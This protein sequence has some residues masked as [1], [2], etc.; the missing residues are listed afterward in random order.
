MYKLGRWVRD[1]LHAAKEQ[2][3]S[4]LVQKPPDHYLRHIIHGKCPLI[5][6]PGV[7]EKWHF[8][9]AIADPLSRQGHPVYVLEHLGYNTRTIHESAELVRK[10]I[11]EQH[12]YDAVIVA[13]SKGGLIGK[14]VLAH[15][16]SDNRVR[17]VIAIATPFRGSRIAHLIPARFLRE[18]SPSSDAI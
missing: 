8:L 14:Y 3:A 11:D 16:N 10:L 13:H 18:L 6:I 9:H 4:F 15:R 1:Y 7:L 17:K 12:L 2:V 5:L